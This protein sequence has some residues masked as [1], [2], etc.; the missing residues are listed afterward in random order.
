MGD[1][2]WKITAAVGAVGAIGALALAAT[3][4]RALGSHARADQRIHEDV[5]TLKDEIAA[6]KSFASVTDRV[7]A[8]WAE[9]RASEKRGEN[10]DDI[11]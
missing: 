10:D 8:R 11:S 9:E 4:R 7:L 6:L 3:N 5:A 1:T 2:V